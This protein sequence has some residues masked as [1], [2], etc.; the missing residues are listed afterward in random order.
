MAAGAKIC[1]SEPVVAAGL[2][3]AFGRR[4]GSGGG[5]LVH[6]LL[7][8]DSDLV[9]VFLVFDDGVEIEV[10]GVRDEETEPL[11]GEIPV[12]ELVVL[13][14]LVAVVESAEGGDEH[15]GV[16]E[17]G[18][19]L[20]DVDN[21]EADHVDVVHNSTPDN[22]EPDDSIVVGS[23]GKDPDDSGRDPLEEHED[24]VDILRDTPDGVVVHSD[25]VVVLSGDSV[26]T[27]RSVPKL[28]VVVLEP[29]EAES[30]GGSSEHSPGSE[31]VLVPSLH[32]VSGV[33]SGGVRGDDLT[34]S[35]GVRVDNGIST[36]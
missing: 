11:H 6:G 13:G 16:V 25:D 34:I 22:E 5:V 12:L 8:G 9:S 29:E 24:G 23:G 33:E 26:L 35:G 14:D 21:N 7:A 28:V 36:C 2:A 32:S 4:S 10:H 1:S 19:E 30:N 27:L 3:V 18:D 15:L 20:D 31:L 17:E